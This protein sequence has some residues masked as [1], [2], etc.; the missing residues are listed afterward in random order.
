MELESY[1]RFGPALI[2][3]QA[4]IGASAD[5]DLFDVL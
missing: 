3:V 5:A 4:L 2:F 1:F